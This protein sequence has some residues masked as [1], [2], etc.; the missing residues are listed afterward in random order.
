MEIVT[1]LDAQDDLDDED[2]D[3]ANEDDDAGEE[4]GE[5]D[6]WGRVHAHDADDSD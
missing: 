1:R 4:G 2:A 5:E 3:D 6:D